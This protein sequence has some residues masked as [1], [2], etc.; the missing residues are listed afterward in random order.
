M[1]ATRSKA[2]TRV[3]KTRLRK[4][5]ANIGKAQRAAHGL[6]H[7]ATTKSVGERIAKVA[8]ASG[9]VVEWTLRPQDPSD[10][11][12]VGCLCACGCSCIA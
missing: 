11:L 1:P 10:L 9:M 6:K 5:M 12:G 4:R 8:G 7:T 2:S 3:N